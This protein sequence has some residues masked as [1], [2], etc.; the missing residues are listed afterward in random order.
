MERCTQISCP[1]RIWLCGSVHV[2]RLKETNKEENKSWWTYPHT[3]VNHIYPVLL[4]FVQCV[5]GV[6]AFNCLVFID[7]CN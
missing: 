3:G 7:E 5:L 6:Y 2:R 4:C 1:M